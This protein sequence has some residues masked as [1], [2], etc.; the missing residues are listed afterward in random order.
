VVRRRVRILGRSR[1]SDAL[2]P[3]RIHKLQHATT[4]RPEY[5]EAPEQNA[6]LRDVMLQVIRNV[7]GPSHQAARLLPTNGYH[8]ESTATQLRQLRATVV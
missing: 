7:T 1:S 6:S 5:G 2:E 4:K 3:L 8:V